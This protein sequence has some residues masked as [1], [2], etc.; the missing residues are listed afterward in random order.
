MRAFT[1][2]VVKELHKIRDMEE[3]GVKIASVNGSNEAQDYCA[4]S[5]W[6]LYEV[7]EKKASATKTSK[8]AQK[9]EGMCDLIQ[10]M[11]A[12]TEQRAVLPEV[13]AKVAAVVIVDDTLSK[14]LTKEET[15][16][17]AEILEAM[18]YGREYLVDILG[19]ALA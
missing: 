18:A 9:W 3:I 6:Q 15:E 11:A 4:A 2:S 7:M 8:A 5:S 17:N 14:Q 13:L 10:K 12:Y 1:H 16:K 19:G